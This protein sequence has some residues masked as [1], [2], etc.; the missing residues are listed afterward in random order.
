MMTFEFNATGD[1]KAQLNGYIDTIYGLTFESPAQRVE[2][3]D[4]LTESYFMAT[5]KV[6]DVVPLDRLSTFILLDTLKSKDTGKKS[7]DDA[8]LSDTQLKHRQTKERSDKY[9]ENYGADGR[10]YNPPTRQQ[11]KYQTKLKIK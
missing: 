2:V 5:G 11:E 3:A 8:I 4:A 9:S 10:N 6:P 1:Y 7:Q